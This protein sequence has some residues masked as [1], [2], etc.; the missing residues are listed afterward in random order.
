MTDSVTE[1]K[2]KIIKVKVSSDKMDKSFVATLIRKVPHK[3]YRKYIQRT[4]KYY[5]HDEGNLAKVGDVVTIAACR[6]I[7]KKKHW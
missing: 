5:V 4:T 2:R 1:K 3:L 7:S 6:P